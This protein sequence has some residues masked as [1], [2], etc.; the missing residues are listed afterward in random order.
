MM[1]SYEKDHVVKLIIKNILYEN[2]V[3]ILALPS[4]S[5]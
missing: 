1:E 3:F 2:I 5:H 4:G